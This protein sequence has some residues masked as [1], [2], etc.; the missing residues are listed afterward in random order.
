[1]RFD[2]AIL[3]GLFLISLALAGCGPDVNKVDVK[4]D[5]TQDRA[6]AVVRAYSQFLQENNKPPHSEADLRPI[7]EKSGNPDELLTS[8]RDGQKFVIIYDLNLSE[9]QTWQKDGTGIIGY[10]A[11]G[12]GKTRVVMQVARN[13]WAIPEEQFKKATFPPG[14]EPK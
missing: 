11:K 2:R 9:P 5:P 7:L 13:A 3:S 14:H 8:A 10:E 4:L 12:D 6:L 1:M